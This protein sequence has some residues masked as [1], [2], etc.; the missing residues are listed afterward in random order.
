[1][2]HKSLIQVAIAMDWMEYEDTSIFNLLS[3]HILWMIH[4][5]EATNLV[6]IIKLFYPIKDVNEI[7][8]NIFLDKR[9]KENKKL[10]RA[11]PEFLERII[12]IIPIF[13]KDMNLK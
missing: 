8:D 12:A 5:Y 10:Q 7:E 11:A 1:M 4:L 3:H 13:V 2:N 9:I 6:R